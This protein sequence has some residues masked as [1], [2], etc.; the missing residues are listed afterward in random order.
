MSLSPCPPCHALKESA[1]T[2]Q[3]GAV[4]KGLCQTLWPLNHTSTPATL[5]TLHH[6]CWTVKQKVSP[7]C[8]H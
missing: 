2:Q 7:L 1:L 3:K 5:A 4:S 6:L 8:D